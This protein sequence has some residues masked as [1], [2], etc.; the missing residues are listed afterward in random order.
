MLTLDLLRLRNSSL[1]V[2]NENIMQ[3][4]VLDVK[5]QKILV[6]QV[7]AKETTDEIDL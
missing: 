3:Y 7:E 4:P 1:Y 5:I 6:A 2:A